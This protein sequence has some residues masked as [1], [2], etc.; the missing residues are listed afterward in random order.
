MIMN[1]IY[2][3]STKLFRM[4]EYFTT[5]LKEMSLKHLLKKAAFKS[6]ICPQEKR[7][8]FLKH[9]VAYRI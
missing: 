1:E 9:N 4:W 2:K 8:Q 5:A 3:T 6:F 7:Q